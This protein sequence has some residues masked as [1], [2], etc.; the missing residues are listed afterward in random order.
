M[1]HL[2]SNSIQFSRI[3]ARRQ[4]QFNIIR[5]GRCIPQ[6]KLQ[7]GAPG[8]QVLCIKNGDKNK[9]APED[10]NPSDASN[11]RIHY[12]T[13]RHDTVQT[14]TQSGNFEEPSRR[15][16]TRCREHPRLHVTH[17]ISTTRAGRLSTLRCGDVLYDLDACRQLYPNLKLNAKDHV[18]GSCGQGR[19]R[20][21]GEVPHMFNICLTFELHLGP[22]PPERGFDSSG[23]SFLAQWQTTTLNK[24]SL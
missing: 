2:L 13:R 1:L 5:R 14:N 22:E 21:A 11:I 18:P 24:R 12:P 8:N 23:I 19:L 7:R 4:L 17:F 6:K 10:G 15:G 3:S 9:E 16:R 20:A